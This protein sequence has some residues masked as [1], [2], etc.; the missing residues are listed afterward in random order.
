MSLIYHILPWADWR[1]AQTAGSYQ[2]A[3]LAAQGF[4]HASTREQVVRV[5]NAVYLGQVGLALLVVDAHRLTAPLKFEP[6]VHPASGQPDTGADELF[7]HIYGALN[8]DAVAQVVDFPA[9]A[10]GSFTLPDGV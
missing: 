7:P 1:A 2:A 5:A 8:L 4:I 9:R 3:S 10:D 6:P